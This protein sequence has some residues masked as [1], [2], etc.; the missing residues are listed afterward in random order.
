MHSAYRFE[1][2]LP[3]NG[4]MPRVEENAGPATPEQIRTFRARASKEIVDR[5]VRHRIIAEMME[6]AANSAA[7]DGRTREANELREQAAEA[8]A[9][10]DRVILETSR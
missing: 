5:V 9:V 3:I 2:G 8:R 4:E 1:T 6:K 7:D 10:A